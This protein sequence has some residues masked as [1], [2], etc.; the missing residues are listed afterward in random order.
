MAH[1][2]GPTQQSTQ[3]ESRI[4]LCAGSIPIGFFGSFTED[5]AVEYVCHEEQ[6]GKEDA[7]DD[8]CYR[9]SL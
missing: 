2:A 9:S 1:R 3:G 5:A 7:D 6:K 4:G 8:P